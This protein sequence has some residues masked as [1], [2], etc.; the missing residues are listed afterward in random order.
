MT[1]KIL[2]S[3]SHDQVSMFPELTV[4]VQLEFWAQMGCDGSRISI[5]FHQS[6]FFLYGCAR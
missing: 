6:S 5:Y 1:L 4:L 3:G 2:K